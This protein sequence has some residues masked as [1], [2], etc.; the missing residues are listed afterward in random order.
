MFVRREFR[1]WRKDNM[2]ATIMQQMEDR[3]PLAFMGLPRYRY[4]MLLDRLTKTELIAVAED[5]GLIER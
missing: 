3:R 1:R 5:L 2:L 4:S